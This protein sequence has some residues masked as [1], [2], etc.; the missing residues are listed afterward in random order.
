M[1][2]STPFTSPYRRKSQ[3]DPCA[4]AAETMLLMPDL[5]GFFLTGEAKTEYTNAT[6]SMFYNPTTKG[7]DW[8]TID[9]LACPE[10]S[11][12]SLTVRA[13]CV[14][15]LRPELAAELGINQAISPPSARTTRPLPW[16]PSPARAVLRS[17]PAV[18]GRCSAWRRDEPHFVRMRVLRR[19]LLQRGHDSGG[20]PPLKNI[21]GL[22]LIQE[23]RRLAEGRHEPQLN[24]IVEEAKKA[25]PFRSI[26]IDPDYGEIFA[27]GRMVEKIRTLPRDEPAG[28]RDRRAD[29]TLHLRITGA[30]IPLGARA[31]EEIW[32][33][34]I[35]TLNIAH[36]GGCQNKLLN[37]FVADHRPARHHRFYRGRSHR[38]SAGPKP[39]R[40]AIF[41]T[42]TRAARRAPFR[43]RQHL[44]AA[45]HAG[46][47][48][49]ISE[50]ASFR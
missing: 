27:G 45:S 41:T 31:S 6:T 36:G 11:S 17:A 44:R 4:D 35:D 48:S 1:N 50:A 10:R 25:E 47:G 39:W 15:N 2:F 19:E 22:W 18:H 21:M 43:G 3:E 46:M 40:W 8:Q 29:R 32:R 42:M 7:W 5:L 49:R 24:D 28:N 14:E 30:Q 26:I 13:R 20:F 33:Q 37:Q 12:R 34:R 23:C 16:L 9:A 38:Q